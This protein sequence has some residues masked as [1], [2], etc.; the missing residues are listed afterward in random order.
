MNGV[1]GATTS[2]PFSLSL[3]CTTNKNIE[4]TQAG[5]TLYIEYDWSCFRM[6][7]CTDLSKLAAF[8]NAWLETMT[9]SHLEEYGTESSRV[10]ISWAPWDSAGTQYVFDAGCYYTLGQEDVAVNKDILLKKLTD[11]LHKIKA[12]LTPMLNLYE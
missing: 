11:D 1:I 10:S 3:F 6:W 7:G 4:I 12:L 8:M 9:P 5:K 2:R